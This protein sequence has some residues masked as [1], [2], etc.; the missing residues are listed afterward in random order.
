MTSPGYY[1]ITVAATDNFNEVD[2]STNPPVVTPLSASSS[3]T[4]VIAVVTVG[5]LQYNDPQNGWTAVP[6]TMFI[7]A[8]KKVTF[9]ALPNPSDASFPSGMPVWGG[10][11]GAS[12]TSATTTVGSYT[13]STSTSDFKTITA[14]CGNTVTANAIFFSLNPNPI[15][16]DG[17]VPNHNPSHI[18]VGEIL[19][20]EYTTS[21]PGLSGSQIGGTQWARSGDGTVTNFGN[22]NASYTASSYGGG[23]TLSVKIISGPS[24]GGLGVCTRQIFAPTLGYEIRQDNTVYHLQ[25]QASVGFQA[26]FCISPNDVSFK[27]VLIRETD[28]T[29]SIA[30]GF[31]SSFAGYYH[32][33]GRNGPSVTGWLS[34]GFDTTNNTWEANNTVIDQVAFHNPPDRLN[35]PPT[36]YGTGKVTYQIPWVFQVEGGPAGNSSLINSVLQTWTT[37]NNGAATASKSGVSPVSANAADPT[38]HMPGVW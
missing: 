30:S 34:L 36:G 14:T 10:T 3:T 11:S 6:G 35:Y 18:G 13:L 33:G 32:I 24:T 19:V 1:L 23:V 37:D 9:K 26:Y 2:N 29:P 20:L 28:C 16:L 27:N 38:V 4:L 25:N 5:S 31:L 12:G 8:G 22:N 15:P 7:L 21:P 17:S